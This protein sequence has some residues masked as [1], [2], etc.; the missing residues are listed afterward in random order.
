MDFDIC[1]ASVCR[2]SNWR[3]RA[4]INSCP[5]LTCSIA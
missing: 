5:L 1:M 2:C 4:C 3:R